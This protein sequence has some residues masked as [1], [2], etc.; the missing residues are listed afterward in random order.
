M[1]SRTWS[2][3]LIGWRICCRQRG[4]VFVCY[5]FVEMITRG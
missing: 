5:V 1:M 2:R 3:H 4:K